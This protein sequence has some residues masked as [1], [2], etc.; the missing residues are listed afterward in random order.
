MLE[1]VYSTLSMV[2]TERRSKSMLISIS[3]SIDRFVLLYYRVR[4]L[5]LTIRNP[6]NDDEQ[7]ILSNE[8]RANSS[9]I[10]RHWSMITTRK[11]PNFSV[12]FYFHSN[13]VICVSFARKTMCSR[14][15]NI[16]FKEIIWRLIIILGWKLKK[17]KWWE[18]I[19]DWRIEVFFLTYGLCR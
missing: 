9:K 15:D 7:N 3:I 4:V 1:L 11:K 16:D 10:I 19:F 6:N 2:M 17:W 18:T 14:I 5:F 8:K 12:F 13:F